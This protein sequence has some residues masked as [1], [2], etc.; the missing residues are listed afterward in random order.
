M[1]DSGKVDTGIEETGSNSRLR[2]VCLRCAALPGTL[3]PGVTLNLSMRTVGVSFTSVEM[4]KMG[5]VQE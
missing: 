1:P 3:A 4:M 5:W 2:G